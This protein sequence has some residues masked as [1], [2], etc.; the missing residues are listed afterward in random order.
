MLKT[1]Y[2]KDYALLEQISIEFEK[3]L[4]IITGETGAGKSILIDAMSLLLGERASNEVIRKGAEKAIV[5]GIFSAENNERIDTLL[6]QNEIE[7]SNELI[8]RRELS[9]KG[10]NRCFLNDTPVA[11][12]VIKEV[13]NLLVDLHGQHEHQ[14]LL[15]TETHI[16]FLDDFGSL[17]QPLSDFKKEYDQL[18]LLQKN[19]NELRAKENLLKE[20]KDLYEFQRKEIEAISP[21]EN[22]DESISSELHILENS[23]QL[24]ELT[25][26]ISQQLYDSEKS[27]Y[28]SLI[29][30][31]QKINTL[32]KIDKTFAET[33]GELQSVVAVIND[34]TNIVRKYNAQIE[35]EPQKLEELRSR[36]QAINLLKKKYGGTLQALLDHYKK[37]LNEIKLA[38]SFEDE[39]KK[40]KQAIHQQ[41]ET[42]AKLASELSQRRNELGK[43]ISKEVKEA[44]KVLGIPQSIFEVKILQTTVEQNLQNDGTPFRFNSRGY[45]EVEFFIS[46]NLGEDTK[47]LSKVASGGEISRIML[48]LKTI[49]ARNDK[50]P[51]LIFDEIDTGI[52]GRISQKVGQALKN[53]AAFHQII[54]I[55]H[56]PQIAALADIHFAVEKKIVEDRVVSSIKKLKNEERIREVAK[57]LSGEVVTETSLQ[58]AKELMSIQ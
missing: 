25:N 30:V 8:V 36:F 49:L 21:L 15:R 43:K 10:S 18:H 55:T 37:I 6:E 56:Q 26:D 3:G 12:N 53:L 1:L 35:L 58:T 48:A 41:K 50:L 46:T 24:L 40:M 33:S 51:L 52:S 9:V 38:E 20:K 5:E 47:P 11:L 23:E 54:S 32:A 16:E 22:E 13:G 28:D 2:I 17:E 19:L 27:I 34:I 44:L 4:N 31:Q 39:I 42:L 45:D 29:N 7:K 57:L 14:S